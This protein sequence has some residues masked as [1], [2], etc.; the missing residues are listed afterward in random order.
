MAGILRRLAVYPVE[1][2]WPSQLPVLALNRALIEKDNKNE[3]INGWRIT[4]YTCFWISACVFLIYYWIPNEFFGALR[5]FNW[6][7]WIAPSS[8]S[9][10]VVTGSYG[11]MGFNPWSTW[12]P[13]VSGFAAV[14]SP[15]FA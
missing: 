2:V 4:R 12:D 13:N 5:L 3:T 1:A 10:A 15:F 8:L 9:L 11:G 7:T 14:N 6:M